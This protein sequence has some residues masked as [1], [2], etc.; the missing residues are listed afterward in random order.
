MAPLPRHFLCYPVLIEVAG[1]HGSG[2]FINDD[3]N[4][5]LVSAKHVLFKDSI[6]TYSAHIE[7]T[8][9]DSETLKDKVSFRLDSRLLVSDGNLRKHSKADVA[10]ARIASLRPHEQPER[11]YHMST[12]AG[13]TVTSTQPWNVTGLKSKDLI[14]IADVQIGTDILLFGYPTSLAGPDFFEKSTPLL[15]TGIVAGLVDDLQI[16]VDC[17]VYFGNSGGL[18][19]GEQ[20][21]R[22]AGMGVA[23]RMIPFKENLYS[24]EFRRQVGTRFENSGYAIVEPMDRVFELLGEFSQATKASTKT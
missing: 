12:T 14:G 9:L 3:L 4:V 22:F 6:E 17:P 19:L 18:V 13:V 20:D 23:S 11:G 8:A 5:Y 21:T 1:T 15:R 2:F 24:A 16:I 7:L 10:I